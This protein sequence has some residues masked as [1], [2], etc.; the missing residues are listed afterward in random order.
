MAFQRESNIISIIEG[1]Q[2]ISTSTILVAVVRDLLKKMRYE[3]WQTIENSYI[4]A[5]DEL[6]EDSLGT[7]KLE[8]SAINKSFFREFIQDPGEPSAKLANWKRQTLNLSNRQIYDCY[9]YFLFQLELK[10]KGFNDKEQRIYLLDIINA[11]L[12]KFVI[13]SIDVESEIAAYNIFQTLN[14]RGL[15]L[16]LAD[17]LKVHL[18]HLAGKESWEAAK[19][20]WDEIRETLSQ[21]RINTFLRHYWLSTQKV[22]QESELLREFQERYK[23]KKDAFDLLDD[24]KAEGEIYEANFWGDKEIVSRLN[25]LKLLSASMPLPLLMSGYQVFKINEFSS[26]LNVCINFIFRYVTIAERD[27]KVLEKLLSDISIAIRA[28]EIKTVSEVKRRLQKEYIDDKTFEQ[29]F[30]KNEIKTEKVAKYILEKIETYLSGEQEKFS[31]KITVEHI[32]PKNP[33]EEW[34]PYLRANQMETASYVYRIGNLTLLL[35]APN[36][37]ARNRFFTKKRDEIYSD[38]KQTKLKINQWV[39]KIESWTDKD[40]DRRQNWL[41]KHAVQIWKF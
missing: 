14:D 36:R 4:K 10:T 9:Q 26:F 21:I 37:K 41:A 30:S 13:F 25:E 28:N 16:A 24:L 22:V 8:L 5:E 11:V 32:L 33:D 34:E 31:P 35:D 38:S 17:L 23:S 2:R 7:Y 12:R 29:L 3:K 20:R 6:S 15:D 39:A 19:E 40:I 27:N 18:F 1:Q